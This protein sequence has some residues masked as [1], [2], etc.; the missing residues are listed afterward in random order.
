M[1]HQP[2]AVVGLDQGAV[3]EARGWTSK[4]PRCCVF[5]CV[6]VSCFCFCLLGSAVEGGAAGKAAARGEQA[7]GWPLRG[8]FPSALPDLC[9][10]AKCQ[11]GC[12]HA[13]HQ[14]LPLLPSSRP[15][16]VCACAIHSASCGCSLCRRREERSCVVCALVRSSPGQ[17][18][19]SPRTKDAALASQPEARVTLALLGSARRR[20]RPSAR[21]RV[22]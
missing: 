22:R 15:A 20:S 3:E 21:H 11:E 14:R 19:G 7:I 4:A 13:N 10:V 2:H 18:V 16:R 1:G 8:V 6:A 17:S 12:S 5:L 9:A